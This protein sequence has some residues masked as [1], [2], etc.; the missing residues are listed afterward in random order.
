MGRKCTY[1]EF[2]AKAVKIHGTK[3]AYV[4]IYI[5][6]Q[7]KMEIECPIHGVYLQT[8]AAHLQGGKCPPCSPTAKLTMEIFIERCIEVHGPDRYN[9]DK[10][11]YTGLHGN[12]IVGCN[13]CGEEFTP[14]AQGHMNGSNC[15]RCQGR[16]SGLN[17]KLTQ[18]EFVAECMRV[19]GSGKYDYSETEYRGKDYPI[20][21]MCLTCNE[22][23]TV[24]AKTHLD[25]STH[26]KCYWLSKRLTLEEFVERCIGMHGK[27][28]YDYSNTK[29]VDMRTAVKIFCKK[30]NREFEMP[31]VE[32]VKGKNCP[33]YPRSMSKGEAAIASI[34]DKLGIKYIMQARVNSP[35]FRRFDFKFKYKGKRYILEYDGIQH[36]INSRIFAAG[37]EEQHEIDIEKTNAAI[38]EGYIIIR[39]DYTVK[40]KNLEHEVLAALNCPLEFDLYCS[41]PSMYTWLKE[42]CAPY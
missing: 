22:K 41:T 29:Y 1:E 40:F 17:G 28:K 6:A 42:A 19:H 31:G 13:T 4:G 32:H 5:S 35:H 27:D 2:V 23:F 9:Y 10:T 26:I 21:I 7:T 3:Y 24:G 36:F 18:E 14:V 11:D 39:I 33:C 34:L 38:D 37:I 25:G 8:P 12:I 20:T 15:P 16:G 30:C